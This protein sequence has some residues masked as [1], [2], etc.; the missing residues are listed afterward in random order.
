MT[1]S[2]PAT[3]PTTIGARSEEHT[4]ELQHSQISYA[5]FCL[6]KKIQ[7]D[8]C[9]V[10][11]FAGSI[12]SSNE[13]SELLIPALPIHRWRSLARYGEPVHPDAAVHPCRSS[14]LAPAT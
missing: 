3:R 5:V 1:T 8:R 7:P 2:R 6:K 9:E 12:P 13:S 10:R 4:S 14:V 11:R